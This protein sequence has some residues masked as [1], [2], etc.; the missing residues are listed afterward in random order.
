LPQEFDVVCLGGGVAGEAIAGGL[1]GSGLSLAVVEREAVDRSGVG[2][3]LESAVAVGD[4]NRD[5]RTDLM[6]ANQCQ[7]A[8]NCNAGSISATAGTGADIEGGGNITN[9][10]GATIS[11]SAFGVSKPS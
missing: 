7:I 10:A 9:L 5:G 2:D 3:D 4:L 11:G 8:S 1:Q 6:L